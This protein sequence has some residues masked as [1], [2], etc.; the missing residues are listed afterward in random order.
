MRSRHV[1]VDEGPAPDGR[2]DLVRCPLSISRASTSITLRR[3]MPAMQ[4]AIDLLHHMERKLYRGIMTPSMIA[5]IVL[6][7]GAMLA[8]NPGPGFPRAG[9][10]PSSRWWC[11][12]S[13]YH[14]VCLI[15]MKKL[16]AGTLS[17][18]ARLLPLVQ[19]AAG[20]RAGTGCHPGGG[21]AVL[22]PMPRVWTA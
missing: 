22:M 2:G 21:Q 4:Q 16:A 10:M 7:G 11:Y 3:V 6:F 1:F 5:V 9:S 13:A 15:Y 17:E 18:I 14:H 19:R 12:W 8:L 20:H